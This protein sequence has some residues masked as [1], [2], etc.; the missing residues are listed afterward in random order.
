MKK[1]MQ[2]LL[3][4]LMAV[5]M[6]SGCAGKIDHDG[7]VSISMYMYDRSMIKELT[8]WLEDKFTDID[9][10]FVQSY[11]TMEYYNLNFQ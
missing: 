10:T 1:M 11:N 5:T 9:F 2:F 6:F 3:T 7:K 8:P 4:G